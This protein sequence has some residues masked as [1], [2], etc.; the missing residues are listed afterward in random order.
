MEFPSPAPRGFMTVNDHRISGFGYGWDRGTLA[1][2]LH[3][4]WPPP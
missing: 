1:A 2:V 4:D 3:K